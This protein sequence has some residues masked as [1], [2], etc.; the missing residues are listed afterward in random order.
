[1]K[2]FFVVLVTFYA[3]ATFAQTI[4][5]EVELAGFL[6]GQYR[7]AVYAQLG[8][9]IQRSPSEDGWIYEFHTLKPDTSVYALF[10]YAK[11]DT[12]R[13]YAIQISGNRYDEM[14]PFRG[15]KLGASKAEVDHVLGTPDK[16]ETVDDPPITLQYYPHKNYSVDISN[17]GRLYGI[18]VFGNILDKQ[19]GAS[20][21][22][23]SF[24]N[25]IVTKNV[26]S[27]MVC[28][29]PDIELHKAG[30][31]LRFSGAAREEFRKKDSEFVK[32]LLGESESVWFVFAK[33]RAEGMAELKAIG[34]G[35]QMSSVDKF[36]DSNVI[37]EIILKPHAG[38]WK[39]AEI[40]FR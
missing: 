10:K 38:K 24:R 27:L 7:T 18:Q 25:A 4:D 12:T 6:I 39:V 1:M 40:K 13:I 28:L 34:S 21:S 36:F 19:A 9:P 23:K 5:G 15:L 22:T 35:N 26:D 31:V 32:H 20:P 3:T 11:W 2:T 16:I 8:A 37:S 17:Q 33:E 30:N 14:H 29:A